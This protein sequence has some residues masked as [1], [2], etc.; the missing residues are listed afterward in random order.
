MLYPA[1]YDLPPI[2]KGYTWDVAFTYEVNNEPMDL[3]GYSA[4]FFLY[5]E[6]DDEQEIIK[7][8]STAG[9]I[10]LRNDGTIV[11][12]MTPEQTDSIPEGRKGYIL[13]LLFPSGSPKYQILV[14]YV[15]VLIRGNAI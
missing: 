4:E 6:F 8:T 10:E 3:T 5:D 15:P 13:D 14:G 7:L 11:I 12:T 9:E 2:I 1:Y